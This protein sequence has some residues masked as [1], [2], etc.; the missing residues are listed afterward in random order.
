MSNYKKDCI[1]EQKSSDQDILSRLVEIYKLIIRAN[2]KNIEVRNVRD[3]IYNDS[4]K[5]N[6]LYRFISF[7]L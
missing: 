4:S 1:R 2:A 6:I 3:T 5:R 7:L